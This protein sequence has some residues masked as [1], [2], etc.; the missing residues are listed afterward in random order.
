M[1]KQQ[2]TE[3][4]T[5][6]ATERRSGRPMTAPTRRGSRTVAF[7]D[8]VSPDC[9]SGG[10]RQEAETATHEAID[11]RSERPLTAPTV[12]GSR[13]VSMEDLVAPHF[14]SGGKR[15]ADGL[16]EPTLIAVNAGNMLLCVPCAV[17][18][19]YDLRPLLGLLA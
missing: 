2:E 16:G 8:V 6:K 18:V 5:R 19:L 17:E 4:A 10:K 13:K 11:P 1:G 7:E 14:S 3:S 12:I 15:P 9:S